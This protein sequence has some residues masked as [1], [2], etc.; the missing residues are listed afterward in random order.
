MLPALLLALAGLAPAGPVPD[1][2]LEVLEGRASLAGALGVYE[3]RAGRPP[4]TLAGPGY[5]EVAPLSRVS[6]HWRQTGSLL[7][8]GPATLEWNPGPERLTWRF[9][10]VARTHL[11][12]RSRD[13][14]LELP[15]GWVAV[16]EYGA[17]YLR[18]RPGGGVEFH[19]DAG[20]PV[21]L[22]GPA[23]ASGTRPPWTVL[24]GARLL[25]EA[26]RERPATLAGTEGRLLEPYGRPESQALERAVPG[27]PWTGFTWPWRARTAQPA[28]APSTERDRPAEPAAG[29]A[30]D[31]APQR[32]PVAPR[33]IAPSPDASAPVE[34][35]DRAVHPT[36]REA[37]PPL[38]GP[39]GAPVSPPAP[40]HPTSGGELGRP[41]GSASAPSEP[42]ALPEP[43]VLP[44]SSAQPEPAPPSRSLALPEGPEDLEVQ[45]LAPQRR[46]APLPPRAADAPTADRPQAA[47]PLHF[48]AFIR[49]EGRLVLTP[50]GA[51]W[52]EGAER[53]QH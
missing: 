39:H 14:R 1:A 27:H 49:R 51:L 5:L 13:V 3:L 43:S 32:A 29:A 9:H 36:S 41:D 47:A 19:H 2:Q 40:A 42:S 11:E 31:G 10:E 6:L 30:G 48:D 15:G 26:G 8:Q 46:P 35:R 21:L 37:V 4:Q 33:P 23:R 24:A 53:P 52:F 12:V 44:N 50:Y 16:F 22:R 45:E 7:V 38:E 28:A 25:L 17:S 34:L 18:G 20:L